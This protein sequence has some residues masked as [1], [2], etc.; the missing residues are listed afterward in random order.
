MKATINNVTLGVKDINASKKFYGDGLGYEVDQDR[1]GFVSFKAGEGGAALSLYTR[2]ALAGDAGVS[3]EGTG[4]R[5]VVLNCIVSGQDRV[6]E[7]MTLAERA[8]A[9]I[10]KPAHKEQWGG[11]S[12][13]FSDPDGH[14][15][16]VAGY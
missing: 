1:G 10:L 8:G 6:G 13:H 15:W 9:Q 2:D 16:K 3:A 14:I 7:V 5:G 11:Y 4:F 12:G